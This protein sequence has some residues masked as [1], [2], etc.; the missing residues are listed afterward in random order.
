MDLMRFW[1]IDPRVWNNKT[2]VLEYSQTEFWNYAG[3]VLACKLVL[4]CVLASEYGNLGFGIAL[5]WFWNDAFLI[6]E[7]TDP[8]FG[9]QSA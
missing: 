6:L 3:L 9:I 5:P 1:N 8:S 2:L 4:G 7:Y